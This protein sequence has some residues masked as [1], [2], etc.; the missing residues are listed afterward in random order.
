MTVEVLPEACLRRLSPS[1]SSSPC[2]HRGQRRAAAT[3]SDSV[4]RPTRTY[5]WFVHPPAIACSASASKQLPAEPQQGH[6]WYQQH[7]V[8][9]NRHTLGPP[10]AHPNLALCINRRPFT[11]RLTTRL[12]EGPSLAHLVQQ[13]TPCAGCWMLSRPPPL[14]SVTV[15]QRQGS[16]AGSN[17]AQTGSAEASY[18]GPQAALLQG[19][20]GAGCYLLLYCLLYCW[21]PPVLAP[22][23]CWWLQ[24]WASAP[25]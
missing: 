25:C 8:N 20:T 10:R 4:G 1:H 6:W 5:L 24:P 19:P 7:F 11:P 15:V 17:L 18:P 23:R 16:S 21:W 3:V 13:S 12:T 22:S 14:C 9:R 2:R